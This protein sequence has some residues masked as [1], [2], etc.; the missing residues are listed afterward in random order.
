LDQALASIF[1]TQDYEPLEVIVVDD[2]STDETPAV[3]AKYPVRYIYRDKHRAWEG[4]AR[5]A[6]VGIRA[7]SHDIMILQN[8]EI[9][10]QQP[11]TIAR[12][13]ARVKDDD[14]TWLM[15]RVDNGTEDGGVDGTRCAVHNERRCGFFLSALWRKHLLEIRGFDEDYVYGFAEDNDLADRLIDFCG[16][17]QVFTNSARGLHLWHPDNM[18]LLKMGEAGARMYARKMGEML[19]GRITHVRNL[20][21]D[22]GTL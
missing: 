18:A 9:V 20:D 12:M 16:L 10:H 19:T 2:G 21:R 22:W 8:A 6:N 17:K 1:L 5:A 7:A 11:D 14:K 3:C 4:Q 15:A 13:V